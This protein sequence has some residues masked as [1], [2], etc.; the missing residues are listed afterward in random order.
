MSRRAAVIGYA[1]AVWV[2]VTEPA[3]T[4]AS[5]CHFGPDR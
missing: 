5:I 2:A 4:W 3:P 1:D